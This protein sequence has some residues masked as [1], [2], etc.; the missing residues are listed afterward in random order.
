MQHGFVHLLVIAVVSL[1]LAAINISFSCLCLQV[2][3]YLC[4]SKF[5]NYVCSMWGLY[6]PYSRSTIGHTCAVWQP[7]LFSNICVQW[8]YLFL[9]HILQ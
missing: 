9:V 7:Y 5:L 8:S 6:V 4:E 2:C 1:H 3:R